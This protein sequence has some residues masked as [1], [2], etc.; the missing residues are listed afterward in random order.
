MET[1]AE[2]FFDLYLARLKDDPRPQLTNLGRKTVMESVVEA[3]LT[4][5]LDRGA[6]ISRVAKEAFGDVI[7]PVLHT[8]VILSDAKNPTRSGVPGTRAHQ[9]RPQMH[10]HDK[11]TVTLRNMST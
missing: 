3:Y 8:T 2:I 11:V 10:S 1:L 5:T 9:E 7:P 6:A 4:G